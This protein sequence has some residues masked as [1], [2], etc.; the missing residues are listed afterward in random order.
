MTILLDTHIFLWQ[1]TDDLRLPELIK[2]EIEDPANTVFLSTVTLWELTIK[3]QTGRLP[4]PQPPQVFVPD[5]RRIHGFLPL[6][7]EEADITYLADLPVLHR[8]PFDRALICQTLHHNMILATVDHAIME[9]DV[10]VL[11]GTPP[12]IT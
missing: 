9:Y 3:W 1:I 10:P 8:D 11:D 12:A 4:L 2:A 7:I 6:P 5:Q